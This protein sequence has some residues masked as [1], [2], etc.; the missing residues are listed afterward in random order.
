MAIAREGFSAF[1]GER[2]QEDQRG[3]NR[4]KR[5]SKSS[6]LSAS[7]IVKNTRQIPNGHF[8][9]AGGTYKIWN[10]PLFR[11]MRSE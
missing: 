3:A 7:S 1:K 11:N 4:D 6:N 8:P 5:F 2:R 10:C 9:V